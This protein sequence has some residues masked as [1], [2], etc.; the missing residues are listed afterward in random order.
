VSPQPIAWQDAV[1]AHFTPKRES[2]L[3]AIDPDGLLRDDVLL[4]AIQNANYD[5]LE[6]SNEVAFRNLFERSYRSRWDNGEARHVV[7][8]VHTMDAERHIPYD[9][10]RKSR[11]IELSAS[12][13]FPNLNA[14]VVRKLDN[15]YYDALYTAHRQ[16]VAHGE[17]LL[18]ERQTIEFILRVVFGMEPAGA[19]NPARWV[20][21]LIGKHYSKRLL[22]PELER[23]VISQL[24]PKA[25]AAG[26]RAEFMDDAAVFYGWLGQQWAGYVA[27]ADGKA[28]PPP[29]DFADMRLRPLL[30]YLFAQGL[31]PRAPA[32][33]NLPGDKEWLA[34]GL[35]VRRQAG[36]GA[37]REESMQTVYNLRARLARFA[38]PAGL[39]LPSG[40]TDLRDWLGL[41]AEWSE[42][43][44]ECN[45]SPMRLLPRCSQSWPSPGRRWTTPSGSSS[46]TATARSAIMTTT[47]G[48]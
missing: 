33:R 45:P 48:R 30:A 35:A 46:E 26:L 15:E 23:Y 11:R 44:Y 38:D 19:A 1:L 43:V 10:W 6:L 24:L 4:A 27:T 18:S 31:V 29:I 32:P 14:L 40:S 2:M 34:M 39:P 21:F 36:R 3:L 12:L 42:I 22:P 8:V 9:L 20:E 25:Q 37:V 5:V 28:A 7:V 17:Q 41:A 16:L 47:R 13:L